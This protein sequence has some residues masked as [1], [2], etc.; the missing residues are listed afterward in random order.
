MRLAL[1]VPILDQD[2]II[3]E[4]LQGLAPLRARGHRVIVVDGGSRDD[5][6]WRARDLADR[7][8]L[9]PRGW[10]WQANAGG[11]A[12]EADSADVLAF[13]P[14]ATR[15]PPEA[16]RAIVRALSGSTSPWGFF[17][18][19]LQGAQAGASLPWRA[20]AALANLGARAT[21]V[22]LAD[23]VL[24]AT[25]AAFLAL[26]GFQAGSESPD[27]DFSLRAR[28]LGAPVVLRPG[29]RLRTGD[30]PAGTILRSAAQ[31]EWWRLACAL[32]LPLR[33]RR[34]PLW[35]SA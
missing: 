34:P 20:A 16:D 3:E 15:L 8:L 28:L 19:R 23:Q 10:S 7:V 24:F 2:R 30:A 18:L 14:P 31:R 29:V 22:G 5:G 13:V 12:P 21:R 35:S 11:R 1:I 6:P 25:R 26:E 17:D 9:A 4:S 27:V 33:P 32:D